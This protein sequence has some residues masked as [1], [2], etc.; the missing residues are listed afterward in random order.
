[1]AR[2]R[3]AAPS[4]FSAP[5][6]IAAY[7]K[8]PPETKGALT[9]NLA[10][11]AARMAGR[12]LDYLRRTT[13]DAYQWALR[14]LR[15]TVA[16]D[17]MDREMARGDRQGT[18]FTRD[19]T[20]ADTVE[21][22]LR[23]ERRIVLAAH[24]GHIQRWPGTNPGLPAMTPMGTHLAD[25]LGGDY[26]VIG[27]TSGTGQI[28]NTGLDFYTV[29]LFTVLEAPQPGSLDALMAASHDGPFATDLRRLSPADT[30]A[31][32]AVS[33]QHAGIGTFYADQS[34]L[35]AFD[36]IVHLPYGTATEPDQAAL[37]HSPR[38]VQEAYSRWKPQ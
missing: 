15:V 21:W 10:D 29:T 33:Q 11:L 4:A 23:R 12:R 17:S 13:V 16:L 19:A 5:A 35:D 18:M 20:I 26:V 36:V 30:N 9:A 24:N 6:T 22:I 2:P 14:S 25:R 27:T 7:G 8:L 3:R 34:P 1:V 38:D 32:R 31:V 28:L 37:A